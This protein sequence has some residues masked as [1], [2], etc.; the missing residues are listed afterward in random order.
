MTWATVFCILEQSAGTI[1]A[2]MPTCL[3]IFKRGKA[4]D[5]SRNGRLLNRQNYYELSN[6]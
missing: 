4:K 3:P 6:K 2:C 5:D 1:V